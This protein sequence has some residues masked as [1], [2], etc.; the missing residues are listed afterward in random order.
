[1]KLRLPKF[2]YEFPLLS[3]ELIEQS[4]RRRTYVV[5][6]IY[7]LILFA[8]FGAFLFSLVSTRGTVS[9]AALGQGAAAFDLVIAAQLLGIFLLMP[10]MIADVV[11]REREHGSLELLLI[12]QLR[13]ADIVLQKLLSRFIPMGTFLLLSTPLIAVAYAYGGVDARRLWTSAY[14]VVLTC[15]WVG[16]ICMVLSIDARK[17]SIAMLSGYIR[18]PMTMLL[19]TILS[20]FLGMAI[21]GITM[22]ALWAWRW[23]TDK[24]APQS[25]ELMPWNWASAGL[26]PPLMLAGRAAPPLW[27]AVLITLPSWLLIYRYLRK[28]QRLLV[29]TVFTTATDPD[30]RPSFEIARVPEHRRDRPRSST[31]P[32]DQ[33]VR[34]FE[35]NSRTVRQLRKVFWFACIVDLPLLIYL[36]SQFNLS[37][38]DY[39]RRQLQGFAYLTAAQWMVG[40]I[41][42]GLMACSAFAPERHGR[43]LDILLATPIP[44]RELVYQKLAAARRLCWLFYIPMLATIGSEWWF[45]ATAFTGFQG[46]ATPALMHML[47]AATSLAIYPWLAMWLG[48]WLGLRIRDRG[49]AAIALLVIL[50]MWVYLVPVV[51]D[52]G[53]NLAGVYRVDPKLT[54]EEITSDEPGTRGERRIELPR[55][56]WWN[57]LHLL[58]PGTLIMASEHGRWTRRLIGPPWLI[59]LANTLLYAVLALL[60]RWLCLR[61]AAQYLGR[62]PEPGI[63]HEGHDERR[64]RSKEESRG[65]ELKNKVLSS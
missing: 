65:D 44:T 39:E 34:W 41:V 60:L 55:E 35:L 21:W 10:A 14:I 36:A 18:L 7:A 54:W 20:Q 63:L 27:A 12:T 23:H 56:V 47:G 49:R 45:E 48:L 16:A 64:T 52:T 11:T 42:L 50:L 2:S 4:N 5:R 24:A 46:F 58:S 59:I 19:L 17:T 22:L 9:I 51:L 29:T 32:D 28:A 3:K 62:V 57:N 40:A 13:P 53:L 30:A 61:R 43:T 33:P 25:D 38:E 31:L 26:V 6:S 15:F 1:M 37:Y 8:V